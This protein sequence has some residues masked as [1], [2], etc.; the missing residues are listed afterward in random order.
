MAKRK[1]KIKIDEPA[2][3]YEVV[4]TIA[5]SDDIQIETFS[6][7]D[8]FLGAFEFIKQLQTD[9]IFDKDIGSAI[10]GYKVLEILGI[11]FVEVKRT[12]I[13]FTKDDIEKA[14]YYG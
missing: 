11:T 2:S 4:F 3:Y 5:E 7:L 6:N 13:E 14:E 10:V 1:K 8:G 9:G 12:K